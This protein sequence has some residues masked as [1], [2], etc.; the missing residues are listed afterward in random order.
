MQTY[1]ILLTNL[2]NVN[3]SDNDLLSPAIV[4]SS[5]TTKFRPGLQYY[6][7]MAVLQ[8]SVDYWLSVTHGKYIFSSEQKL[9]T[10]TPVISS[11]RFFTSKGCLNLTKSQQISNASQRAIALF[12]I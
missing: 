12:K 1:Y 11:S 9:V 3:T 10:D 6:L 4:I 2:T 5:R 8:A 7:M